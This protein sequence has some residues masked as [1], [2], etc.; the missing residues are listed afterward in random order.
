MDFLNRIE[1]SEKKESR[2]AI[3]KAVETIIGLALVAMPI[4]G[5]W[6]YFLITGEI[7]R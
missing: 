2:D 7:V 3:F 5:T 6:A 1:F 4:W